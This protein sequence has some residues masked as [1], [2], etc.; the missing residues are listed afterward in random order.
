MPVWELLSTMPP[1]ALVDACDF[2][3][4]SDAITPDGRPSRCLKHSRPAAP[5]RIAELKRTGYPAYT[6]SPG[7]LGYSD[8]KMRRL[9]REAVTDGFRAVKLKVSSP[10]GGRAS[11]AWAWP[12]KSSARTS[13]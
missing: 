1:Q 11:A 9:V 8:E 2:R 12:A 10:A 13:A 5:Y 3:Y 7:W 6:T 4:L